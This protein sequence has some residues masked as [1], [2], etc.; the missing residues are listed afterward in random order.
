MALAVGTIVIWA[1]AFGAL[2]PLLATR[3]KVDPTLVSG[4]VMSTLVD[5]VGLFIYF[6]IAR[7]VLG[8]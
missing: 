7:V 5:A 4:P 8:L 6:S 3:L 1:N 2:L